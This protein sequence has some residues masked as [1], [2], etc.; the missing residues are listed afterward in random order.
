M[1]LPSTTGVD[2]TVD[3]D[4]AVGDEIAGVCAGVREV[5]ELEE[6]PEADDV[7]ADLYVVHAPIVS[8][9]RLVTGRTA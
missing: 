6:L 4:F 7:V 3:R 1:Q 9:A 8:C 5:R 2:L